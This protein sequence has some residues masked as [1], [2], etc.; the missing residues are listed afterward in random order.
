MKSRYLLVVL[1]THE[2]VTHQKHFIHST[3]NQ[4]LY[5]NGRAYSKSTEQTVTSD[6]FWE[7]LLKHDLRILITPREIIE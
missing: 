1:D 5:L 2:C 7:F 6:N 3:F 4:Y